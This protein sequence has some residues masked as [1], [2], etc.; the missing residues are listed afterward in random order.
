MIKIIM[1]ITMITSILSSN[2]VVKEYKQKIH[3]LQ[4]YKNNSK[5]IKKPEYLDIHLSY[6]VKQYM[7]N[8]FQSYKHK[9]ID[10]SRQKELSNRLKEMK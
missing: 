10:Y 8:E 5:Y 7:N 6:E 3:T 4:D 9:E 2:I 1:S